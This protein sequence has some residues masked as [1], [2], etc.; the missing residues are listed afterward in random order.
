MKRNKSFNILE[1][2]KE[3]DIKFTKTDTHYQMNCFL[4]TDQR[5]RLGIVIEPDEKGEQPWRCFNCGTSG[6]KAQNLSW[7]WTN[8]DKVKTVESAEKD[9]REDKCT[10]KHDLHLKFHKQLRNTK[11]TTAYKYLKNERKITK[12]AVEH[13]KLGS[14]SIFTFRNED[15]DIEKYNAGEHLAIPYLREGKCMNIKY[16]SLDPEIPK[17]KKWRREKGGV[18]ILFNEDVL[19]EMDY[20]EMFI[21]E[22]EIDTISLWELGIKNNV[23][24]TTGADAFKQGWKD[25]LLRYERI[26]LVLDRDE[27]GQKGARKIA[28]QLGL[29]RCFNIILPDDVKDP[30][31]FI[32]KYSKGEFLELAKKSRPFEVEGVVTIKSAVRDLWNNLDYGEADVNG[33]ETPW[34]KFN[35]VIGKFKPGNLIVICGKPKAGKTTLALD[36]ARHIS[37]HYGEH[38]G[39]FSCEMKAPALAHKYIQMV[40]QDYNTLEDMTIIDRKYA[41]YM[42]RKFQEKVHVRYPQRD[43]LEVD[44]VEKIIIEMVQRY[45]IKFFIFDNLHFLCRGENEKELIDK[46][47]QMFKL[48]AENLGITICLLTHPRKTNN[49]KQ[50][51]NEDMKGSSSI[52]Q[53]A[54]LVILMH[55]PM[56]DAD[57][58]PDEAESGVSDGAMS[59]RA[60]FLVTGRFVEGGRTY[61]AFDGRRSR[62][63][64]RGSLYMECMK[65]L[66]SG[67]KKGKGKGL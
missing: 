55:R 39:M 10:I 57:M 60:E 58:T 62:F 32:Q 5:E 24:L 1:F 18:S 52:F 17:K 56:N 66:R 63:W 26:Y 42:M 65:T 50:L 22:S 15:G 38:V 21:T 48:L 27:A 14:K 31:D 23:G 44:K 40:T 53:D 3:H 11:K 16:R 54:D 13:F 28:S 30:N 20:K 33:F 64:D 4:C 61:L 2:M 47:T 49:N 46:A 37:D 29:G 67:K 25:R 6:K 45:G 51:K 36:L 35:K 7:A 9:K 12:E 43:E 8:K 41:N 19:N 34:P 59:P